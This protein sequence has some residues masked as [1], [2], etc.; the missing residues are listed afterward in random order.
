[1]TDFQSAAELRQ[2]YAEVRG[3]VKQWKPRPKPIP[4]VEV[5]PEPEP[6]PVIEIPPLFTSNKQTLR[7][8]VDVVCRDY[9]ITREQ[10]MSECRRKNFAIPRHVAWYL[11]HRM[12]TLS[13]A[14]LGRLHNR[15]HTSIL[16]GIRKMER[17][18]ETDMLLA[19][20]VVELEQELRG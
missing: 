14:S 12:T 20:R 5:A 19:A 4:I 13:L 16:Y 17:L 11:A 9:K 15:D 2:H 3:R 18:V 8:I 6:I 1:M 10:F 7:R